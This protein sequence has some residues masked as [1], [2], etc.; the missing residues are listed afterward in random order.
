[1]T[2]FLKTNLCF[3]VKSESLLFKSQDERSIIEGRNESSLFV[4]C[5]SR[6]LNFS[7]INHNYPPV[8]SEYVRIRKTSCFFGL[9]RGSQSLTVPQCTAKVIDGAVAVQS[10][11]PTTSKTLGEYAKTS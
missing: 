10:L 8:I 6:E 5:Q 1:M 7:N 9:P 4:A 2:K 3:F 11:K